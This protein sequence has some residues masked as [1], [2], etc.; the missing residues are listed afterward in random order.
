MWFLFGRGFLFLW[1]LGMGYFIFFMWHS[2]SL[3]YNYIQLSITEI[4]ALSPPIEVLKTLKLI[5]KCDN[6]SVLLLR[7]N[8]KLD[9]RHLLQVTFSKNYTR[10][11]ALERSILNCQY[12]QTF[13]MDSGVIKHRILFDTYTPLSPETLSSTQKRF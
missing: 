1:V 10:I 8:T 13:T 11:T 9:M 3:P 7:D 2:L 12:M 5:L 4:S 6:S